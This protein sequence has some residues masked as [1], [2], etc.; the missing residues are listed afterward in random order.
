MP[1]PV[2]Y[3]WQ[4]TP[5]VS[6]IQHPSSRLSDFKTLLRVIDGEHQTRVGLDIGN[7][8]WGWLKKKPALVSASA[9]LSDLL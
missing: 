4:N 2:S 5:T 7:A 9:G 8:G 6:P 1:Q 3:L